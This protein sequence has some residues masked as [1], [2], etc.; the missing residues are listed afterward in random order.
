VVPGSL[1]IEWHPHSGTLDYIIAN[2]MASS[3]VLGV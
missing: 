2:R 1:Q 3:I